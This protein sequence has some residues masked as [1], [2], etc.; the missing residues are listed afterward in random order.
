MALVI[1]NRLLLQATRR[2]LSHTALLLETSAMTASTRGL[3]DILAQTLSLTQATLG[4][5]KAAFLF[6][7]QPT[8]SL[9]AHPGSSVGF[10]LTAGALRFPA[11][12]PTNQIAITYMANQPFFT[13]DPARLRIPPVFLRQTGIHALVCVPAACPE[14]FAGRLSGREPGE[15]AIHP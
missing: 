8:H 10:D 7:D 9:L 3:P 15:R 11:D 5:Q 6:Y 4:I 14:R 2:Q 12:D 13:N 1:D